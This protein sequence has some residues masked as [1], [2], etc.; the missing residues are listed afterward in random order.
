MA[1]VK[2]GKNA[3]VFHDQLTGVTVYKGEVVD[4]NVRQL[5]SPRIKKALTGGHLV[6]APAEE[7]KTDEVMVDAEKLLKNFKAKVEKG[8]TDERLKKAFSMEKLKA[9]CEFAEI[10]VEEGDTALDLIEALKNTTE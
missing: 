8:L 6:Y 7:V 1:K 2:L 5:N 4:L 10:E 9:M 3:Q